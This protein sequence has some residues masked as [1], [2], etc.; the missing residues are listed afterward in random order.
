M[1]RNHAQSGGRERPLKERHSRHQSDLNEDMQTLVLLS[2]DDS[3][4]IM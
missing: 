3:F 1:Y 4:M 2:Y